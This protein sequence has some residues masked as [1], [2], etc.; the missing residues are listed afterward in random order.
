VKRLLALLVVALAVAGPAAASEQHPTL[1]ELERL[2]MCPVC[3]EPLEM[4]SSAEARRIELYIQRRID[5]GWTRSRILNDLVDQF[6]PAI[7]VTPPKH[8]FDLLAWLLPLLGAGVAAV[9]IGFAA[10]HWT[11]VRARDPEPPLDAKLEHELDD[12]LA[13]FDA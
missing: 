2:V 4:S 13:R 9:V 12:A 6:G 10:R 11:R 1:P 8:G 5:Q 3:H 7:L